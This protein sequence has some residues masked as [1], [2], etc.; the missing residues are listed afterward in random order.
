MIAQNVKRGNDW[1]TTIQS[2]TMNKLVDCEYHKQWLSKSESSKLFQ[3]ALKNIPWKEQTVCVWGKKCKVPR[4]VYSY[5]EPGISYSYSGQKDIP[6]TNWPA[7]MNE[8]RKKL[9]TI[10]PD[11]LEP[12][13]LLLN[14]YRNGADKIG[15]HSD[16][17]PDLISGSHIFSIT[18]G[19]ERK[20]VIRNV[21]NNLDKV[22][23]T[24][25]HGSLL[26]M[27]GDFQNKYTHEIPATTQCHL[28]RIN[29]TFRYMNP[30]S[31]KK[32]KLDGD[33]T[34]IDPH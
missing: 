17:E 22:E 23:T 26:D 10:H 3:W 29:L 12:N 32:R 33:T 13:Y 4:L 5:G 11:G 19:A 6:D 25:A 30:S 18:L 1:A 9:A 34:Q 2:K 14:Y 28:G 31:K 24:L 21:N 7:E 20:F 27:Y 15:A 8:I 16:D